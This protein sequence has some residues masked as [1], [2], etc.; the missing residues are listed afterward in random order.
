MAYFVAGR[1]INAATPSPTSPQTTAPSASFY[2]QGRD[3]S[4]D[5]KIINEKVEYSGWRKVTRRTVSSPIRHNHPSHA[6]DRKGHDIHRVHP[7]RKVIDFD[8]ID[9]AHA[10]GGA[11][12]IFAWNST[13]KTA[14]I[15][16]EYMPGPHRV[17]GGLAAGIVEEGK[18]S[19]VEGVGEPDT[20]V[21]ARYELEE[22]CHLAGGTWYRLTEEG[23]SVPMDKYVVTEI[24]PY[25]VIDP[26]HVLDPR[27]LDHEEDIEIVPGVSVEEISQMV[28]EGDFN[29]VGGWGAMLALEKLRELGETT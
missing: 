23:V 25:L 16:R 9:Q 28:R 12:I 22:E 7:Q 10:T 19:T 24:T 11:V 1:T 26:Q 29:L 8:I 14:T 5:H 21:A 18:H 3:R 2:P 27:P 17:L 4:H 6:T 13:S 20:L 15:I